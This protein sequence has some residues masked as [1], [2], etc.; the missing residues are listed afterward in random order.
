M[1]NEP[2]VGTDQLAFRENPSRLDEKSSTD[3]FEIS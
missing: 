2:A 1:E 3:S